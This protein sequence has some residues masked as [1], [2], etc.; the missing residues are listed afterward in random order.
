MDL[1]RA[2]RTLSMLLLL[3]GHATSAFAREDGA[4]VGHPTNV[5]IICT[6]NGLQMIE[7]DVGTDD[8][9]TP[10]SDLL[11]L[12]C[13]SAGVVTE[14]ETSGGRVSLAPFEAYAGPGERHCSRFA[15]TNHYTARAPP[16]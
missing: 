14:I 16:L 12:Q 6:P 9:P 5:L 15:E 2:T 13:V 7:W 8:P 4:S 1:S 10:N 3:I 11:C